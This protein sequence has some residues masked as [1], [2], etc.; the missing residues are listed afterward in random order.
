MA[1]GHCLGHI[2]KLLAHDI[3]LVE[4]DRGCRR[5]LSRWLARIRI[6]P[7]ADRRGKFRPARAVIGLRE[8]FGEAGEKLG[9]IPPRS[10]PITRLT[11]LHLQPVPCLPRNVKK[12]NQRFPGCILRF[13]NA[14]RHAL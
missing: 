12:K 9:T 5:G 3:G 14:L 2:V 8:K 4:R 6:A 1:R 10:T 13:M 11:R 7:F